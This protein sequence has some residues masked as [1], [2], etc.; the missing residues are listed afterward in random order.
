MGIFHETPESAA[1]R[2]AE[3]WN[4]VP[5]WWHRAEVQAARKEFCDRFA[6]IPNN[7][8]RILKKALTEVL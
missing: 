7:Q 1:A 8:T 2:V 6:R 4:D 3:V 5:E